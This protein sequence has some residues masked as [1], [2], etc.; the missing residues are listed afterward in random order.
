[1]TAFREEMLQNIRNTENKITTNINTKISEILQSIEN[2]KTKTNIIIETNKN[3]LESLINQNLKL[4]RI[5]ELCAFKNK[6]EGMVITHEVRINNAKKDIDEMRSKYDKMICDNLLVPGYI[7]SSC[8]FRTISEYLVNN[9]NEASKL[10]IERETLKRDMKELKTKYDGLLKSMVNLNDISVG[11]CKEYTDTKEKDIRGFVIAKIKEFDDKIMEIRM[12]MCKNQ[13][14][15]EKNIKD[16]SEKCRVLSFMRGEILDIVDEKI[17]EV[18]NFENEMNKK[19]VLNIQ[20][21]GINKNN[22]AGFEEKLK[23]VNQNIKDIFFQLR[24]FYLINNKVQAAELFANNRSVSPAK[25]KSSTI[26]ITKKEE[27][28]YSP[29][30]EKNKGIDINKNNNNKIIKNEDNFYDETE[31]N[32]IIKIVNN[33]DNSKNNRINK[34]QNLKNIEI[35]NN[36][37]ISINCDNINTNESK[38][39]RKSSPNIKKNSQNLTKIPEPL[40]TNMKQISGVETNRTKEKKLINKKANTNF[41]TIDIKEAEKYENTNNNNFQLNGK[42]KNKLKTNLGI[43]NKLN[44]NGVLDLYSYSTSPPEG[45]D[46]NL[47]AMPNLN[48]PEIIESNG[49][50]LQVDPD[51]GAECNIVSLDMNGSPKNKKKKS[52]IK[53]D[54]VNLYNLYHTSNNFYKVNKN[55]KS[56]NCLNTLPMKVNPAFGR[57]AYTFFKKDQVDCSNINNKKNRN[58]NNIYNSLTKN[59]NIIK[60]SD[61]KEKYTNQIDCITERNVYY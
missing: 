34:G 26:V 20:D 7:G 43:F 50:K 14:N 19:I 30:H 31:Q 22:I 17:Q 61:S 24:N 15:N 42:M 35:E 29:I 53:N 36:N 25:K 55:C 23:D 47:F 21:I 38:E 16:L 51:T 33:L 41:K 5:D 6:V 13:E 18:Q 8:Q 60:K 54:D 40:I 11:R 49:K 9:I 28:N 32:E 3:A 10:K 52:E 58:N 4:E 2:F 1:M 57:T 39:K 48:T 56:Q 59:K 46:L 45:M 44:Q 27:N 37:K 12:T